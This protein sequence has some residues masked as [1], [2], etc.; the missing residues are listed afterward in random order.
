LFPFGE[1]VFMPCEA[2][3]EVQPLTLELLPLM[4]LNMWTGKHV[5]LRVVN[6]ICVDLDPMDL[7]LHF[8]NQF[9]IIIKLACSLLEA[10]AGSCLWLLLLYRL[11]RLVM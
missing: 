11:Q 2:S 9:C 1:D 7:I 4:K 8:A 3:I 10:M 6:V 5:P